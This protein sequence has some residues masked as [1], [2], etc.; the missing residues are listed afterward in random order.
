MRLVDTHQHLWDLSRFNLP[1]TKGAG[2][3]LERNHLPSD[4]EDAIRGTGIDTAVYMEVD[5][6]NDQKTDEAR[7]ACARG[8]AVVG[9]NPADP[10]FPEYLDRIAHPNL[11]GVRQVLHGGLP[12]GTCISEPFVRGARELGKRQ[13]TFD[14]CMRP[15][16][17]ADGAK[18]ASLCPDTRFIL[19][20][21]GNGNVRFTDAERDRW[22]LGVETVAKQPNTICKISGIVAS[23]KDM[24]WTVD[25]LAPLVNH[26]W[27]S[28]G[29]DRVVFGSDWPVCTLA[30][31]LA[32]WVD[33]LRQIAARRSEADQRKLF[34]ENAVRV[35]RLTR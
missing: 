9:G 19:D 7:V 12:A 6:A 28:F 13:L 31:S 24:P 21:C 32:Q 4:Y 3:P 8:A 1:W 11:R 27:D 22:K 10:D 15:F 17:L 16:E 26:C 34:H 5:V 20:H 35:Y 33:A 18:L 23:A 14:L 2:L 25:D 30:A 29:P